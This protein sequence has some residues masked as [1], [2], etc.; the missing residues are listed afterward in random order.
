ML[1]RPKRERRV[2]NKTHKKTRHTHKTKAG[3]NVA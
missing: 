2:K 3:K 1:A